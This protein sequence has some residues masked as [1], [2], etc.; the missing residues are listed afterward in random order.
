MGEKAGENG[1]EGGGQ[2]KAVPYSQNYDW[3]VTGDSML[4][5]CTIEVSFTEFCETGTVFMRA[6]SADPLACDVIWV[7]WHVPHSDAS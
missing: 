3:Y 1:K 4:T 2:G 6:L 5:S 7:M